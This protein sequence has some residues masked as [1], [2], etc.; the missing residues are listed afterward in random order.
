MDEA[1]ERIIDT[2]GKLDLPSPVVDREV[3]Q[4]AVD[5]CNETSQPQNSSKV[6]YSEGVLGSDWLLKSR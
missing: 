4:G 6:S 1:L 3:L 2:L 5:E